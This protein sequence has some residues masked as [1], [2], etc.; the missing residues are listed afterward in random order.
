MINLDDIRQAQQ[1]LANVTIRTPLIR[2][3]CPPREFSPTAAAGELWFKPENLQPIGAFKLRGAYNHIAALPEEVRRRGVITYS[4]G[5]HAQGVA[6]AARALGIKAVVVM[7]NDAPAGKIAA[8]RALGAEVEFVGPASSE[9]QARAEALAAEYHY[10]IVPPYN[11]LQ[12]IA[13]QATAGLEIVQALPE[14][15]L[16]LVPIGGGGLISGI[17]AAIKLSSPRAKVIGVEPVLA[18]DALASFQSGK[19]VEFAAEQVSRTIADGLRTQHIGLHNFEH[20]RRY[21]D[22]I[23]TVTEDEIIKATAFLALR[24]RLVA[25]PS[26]AVTSA[27]FLFHGD[28]LPRAG[29]TIAVISGGN[30]EPALLADILL[31]QGVART[32]TG[33]SA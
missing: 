4:S 31:G 16:V 1:R 2:C 22:D 17:A 29:R 26:G 11:D 20:I 28:E 24:A 19:I 7:P 14:V 21:V 5:N 6:Y 8:T 23:I 13:G 10:A 33:P 9:R 12:I 30:I 32:A 15:E 18:S 3:S 25:E 27:A